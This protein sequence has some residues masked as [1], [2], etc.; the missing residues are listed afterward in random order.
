MEKN[1]Q[2]SR[3]D[4]ID[5]HTRLI[6][7]AL[8]LIAAA[9]R[10]YHLASW[11]VWTDEAHT[12]EHCLGLDPLTLPEKYPLNF[13][14]T[15]PFLRWLGPTELGG[16]TF[17]YLVSILSIP[18]VFLFTRRIFDSKVALLSAAFVTFS[19]WHLDW[20]QNA[21]HY[22]LLF[23]L[24]TCSA[25]WLYLGLET[26]RLKYI[27]LSLVGLILA[28]LT[29]TSGAF[30]L[31]AYIMYPFLVRGIT[32]RFPPGWNARNVLVLA[33][34]LA[35]G[36]IVTIPKL[37]SLLRHIL[38]ERE[39]ANPWWNVMGSVG[40]YL[41]IPLLVTSVCGHWALVRRRDHRGVFS[42]AIVAA[43]GI[44][45]LV[46][47]L[48][49][50]GSGAYNF[51]TLWPHVMVASWF[52]IELTRKPVSQLPLAGLALAG[53]I[54]FSSMADDVF[55]FTTAH[56]NRPRWKEAFEYVQAQIE[57]DDEVYCS[58]GHVARFYLGFDRKAGWL[59]DVEPKRLVQDRQPAWI[60]TLTATENTL[61]GNRN[62]RAFLQ[63]QCQRLIS[64]TSHTALK[65]R[66]VTV[67]HWDPDSA[68]GGQPPDPING[69]QE[70]E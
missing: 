36:I 53:I 7:V 66:I 51:Y 27:L 48:V 42:L 38:F 1:N 15:K 69:E 23:V 63:S 31:P 26:D 44:S 43:G 47:T 28:V 56:G 57:P 45:L 16:R 19:V 46:V 35:V 11:S 64:F 65:K 52:C 68:L 30:L 29:H 55:Y 39:A 59:G 2:N 9:L 21:R 18:I 37:M 34:P 13:L 12:V 54:L 60:V 24:T 32:G 3:T 33:I 62:L 67:Y 40:F 20:S 70:G 49:T 17:P 41:G 10:W 22:A 58:S 5:K 8:V 4:F 14:I 6:L 61:P 50:W 25:G